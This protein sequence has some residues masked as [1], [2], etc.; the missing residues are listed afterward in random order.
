MPEELRQTR[1]PAVQRAQEKFAETIRPAMFSLLGL[2][3]FCH[4]RL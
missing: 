2:A 3:L 4:G 1:R